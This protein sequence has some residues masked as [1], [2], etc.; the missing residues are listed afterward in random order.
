MN[1]LF[2]F[3]LT[4]NDNKVIEVRF[5]N[6]PPKIDGAIEE[7][8][9][10]ADSAYDFIQFEPYEKTE[11]TERTVV[12][13]L[14]DK[15]NLYFAF[16]CYAQKHKPTAC[17]TEDEDDVRIGIDPFNSKNTAYF[18]Q[19]F[20]SGLFY[21]GWILD[22][23]RTYDNAW[24]GIWF[25]AVKLY[26]DR[27]EVEFKIPFKSIRYKKGLDQWGIGFGRYIAANRETDCWNEYRQ[28]E[29]VLVSKF[30]ALKGVKP[31]VTGY[32]FEL[33][34]EGFVRYD[35]YQGEDDEFKPKASL[36]LKWDLTPQTTLNA[37]I[38]PD[39]AQIESDPFTLNLSRYPTY[40]NERRPF[41]LEG[42][43]IFRMSDFGE[44]MNFFE[45]LNIFYSRRI[46]KSM[47]G[48]AVPIIAGA[49]LTNKSEK[50]NLGVLG[51]YTDKYSMNDTVLEQARGF[52]VL[53]T[54][55]N[56]FKNSDIGMLFSGTMVDKDVYNYTR[57]LDGVY[58]K[59]VTQLIVQGAMSDKNGG[60]GWALSSGFSD[61]I[62]DFFTFVS[63]MIVSNSFDVSDIGFVPWPGQK[64]F[65]LM[66]GPYKNFPKGFLKDLYIAP[67]IVVN[68]EPGNKNWSRL[69]IL[70]INPNFR[71]NW[72]F[73]ISTTLGPYYEADTNYF[74][75]ELNFVSWGN[76]ASQ[77]FE[78]GCNYNYSY[79]YRRGY[80]A[81]Q[82]SNWLTLNY[83]IIPQLI[84]GSN[85]RLWIEWDTLNTIIAM[86]P[87]LRPQIIVR[88]NAYMNLSLFSELVMEA[89]GTDLGATDLLSNRIG[90]LFSWNF[91]PK[92]WLYIALNDY[93]EQNETG[94]LK[95][96]YTIGAIKAKYLIYF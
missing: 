87:L 14:Q 82:G 34:P 29:G 7:I 26:D 65:M 39:F 69:G 49:K 77:I 80:L 30:G 32:Y 33:Y 31:Q 40:L 58:R 51:A 47:N 64:Q 94:Q 10:M 92:S 86:T 85:T 43:E 12:Y 46:G 70:E 95:P 44:N 23:G 45:P 18:F 9:Q 93:R 37:A 74:Y 15:E 68:Q 61:L 81:Y 41:F 4:I 96:Q 89:P 36:N 56:L 59:G 16:R 54:K 1:F 71:N 28:V 5:T 13:V 73:D 62:G 6:I 24:E 8:W 27:F 35:Q 38:Y 52:G 78:C 90:M 67:G 57:G 17:L 53:R 91:R 76:L 25:H 20:G 2:L 66:S 83:S 72:G 42:Q 3:L 63:A 22:D 19:I 84:I 75:R 55:R 88:F 60:R 79:N 11:P 21:E 50:W 48:D